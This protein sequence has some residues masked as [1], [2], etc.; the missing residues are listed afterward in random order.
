MAAVQQ[1]VQVVPKESVRLQNLRKGQVVVK[2]TGFLVHRSQVSQRRWGRRL[3]RGIQQGRALVGARR[4]WERLVCVNFSQVFFVFRCLVPS[5]VQYE[6]WY[7]RC[8]SF[9]LRR[10]CNESEYQ[11]PLRSLWR[12]VV[13]SHQ[14][15]VTCVR[16]PSIMRIQRCCYCIIRLLLRTRTKTR[17]VQYEH[18]SN[19]AAGTTRTLGFTYEPVLHDQYHA[20]SHEYLVLHSYHSCTPCFAPLLPDTT[21]VFTAVQ[22]L[23]LLC[24]SLASCARSRRI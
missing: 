3:A 1:K 13:T 7:R 15:P 19:T 21:S 6:C 14:L 11:A 4:R 10:C 20:M 22:A 24:M 8:C 2:R 9:G 18:G 17:E 23:R 12:G 5:R 16:V